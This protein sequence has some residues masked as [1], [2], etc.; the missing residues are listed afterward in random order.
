MSV[1]KETLSREVADLLG[2][3]RLQRSGKAYHI[4]TTIVNAMLK[5]LHRGERIQIEGFG[6]FYIR[7]RPATRRLQYFFPYLKKKGLHWEIKAVAAKKYV[8]FQPAKPL[9]MSLNDKPQP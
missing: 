9:L 3:P 6:I 2:L 7:E 4:V 1:T 5:A 8:V